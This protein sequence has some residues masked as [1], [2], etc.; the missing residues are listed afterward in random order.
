MPAGIFKTY[1][2]FRQALL[3]GQI[4]VENTK[5]VGLLTTGKYV[6]D[7]SKDTNL[8]NVTDELTDKAYARQAV[9]LN[10]TR[11]DGA[12]VIAG[13]EVSFGDKVTLQAKHFVVF[14]ENAKEKLLV[15]AVDLNT[16]GEAATSENGNFDIDLKSGILALK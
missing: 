7:F 2:T 6:P 8:S 15:A 14:A 5:F 4:D 11:K 3:A 16:A 10:V 9:K 13:N 1:E 12:I